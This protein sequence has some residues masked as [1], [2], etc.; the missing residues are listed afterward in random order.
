LSFKSS[1]PSWRKCFDTVRWRR[2]SAAES[3]D[4]LLRKGVLPS[5]M[6]FLSGCPSTNDHANF[7]ISEPTCLS[8]SRQ[9]NPAPPRS[10][11]RL[12]VR[13]VDPFVW[14]HCGVGLPALRSMES[15]AGPG[16]SSSA[17]I[18]ASFAN[19]ASRSFRDSDCLKR[20]FFIMTQLRK[21]GSQP[22][23][24]VQ[25]PILIVRGS[26]VRSVRDSLPLPA[27]Q[28]KHPAWAAT[29]VILADNA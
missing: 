17:V 18:P 21:Y 24:V 22:Q 27:P 26:A 15:L 16:G 3:V 13:R 29:L 28:R 10:F 20:R 12:H 4:S 23:G 9:T 19:K 5:S 7:E 1:N 14:M 8:G 2:A 11:R 25:L 6:A